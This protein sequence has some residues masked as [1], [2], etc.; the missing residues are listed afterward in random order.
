MLSSAVQFYRLGARTLHGDEFGSIDE[1]LNL[2]RNLNSLPYFSTL[3]AWLALG[4]GEFWLRTLSAL[5]MV[6]AVAVTFVWVKSLCGRSTALV[7]SLLL[8]TSP[9]LA[10]YGQQ[11][12][13]YGLA[14]LAASL[15][16]WAFTSYLILPRRTTLAKWAAAGLFALSALL[17]NALL[18]AGEFITLFALSRLSRRSKAIIGAA[19]LIVV[20]FVLLVPGVRQLGFDTL[21]KYTNAQ[22]HY[23]ASRGLALSQIAKLPLTFFFFTFGESVYPLTYWLVIPGLVFV[24]VAFVLGIWKLRS[25]VSVLAFVSIAGMT[26]LLALYLVF[27]PLSPPSLQGA[28]PRYLIFLLPLFYLVLAAGTR[29]KRSSLLIVPL[30]LVNFG[31]LASYWYGDWAYTDDL[32]DWR[33]VSQW[34]SNYVTPQTLVLVD[35][36]SQDLANRYFPSSWHIQNEWNYQSAEDLTAFSQFSRLI[37]LSSNYNTDPRA[38]VSALIDRVEYGYDQVA[39]WSKYPLFIEVFDRKQDPSPAFSVDSTGRVNIP[40]EIYGIEFQDLGLP[41]SLKLGDRIVPS[42][43]A[44]GLPGL[45]KQTARSLLLERPTTARELV[46]FS[47][48]IDAALQPGVVVANLSIVG[49]DGSTQTFPLRVGI[50]TSAWNAHCQPDACL[51]A[52]TW[53]KRLALVGSEGYPGSWQQFDA[54]VFAAELSLSSPT[55]VESIELQRLSNQGTLYVWGIALQ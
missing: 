44:F 6:A 12:R 17:L 34:T 26:A 32:T 40:S 22:S 42:L 27:D 18:I 1:A 8:A 28:A 3:R 9:F 55:L 13:F 25:N 10:V 14:L 19:F 54:S 36:R 35:G 31:G 5:A 38:Q 20:L 37:V 30:L 16:V 53:T 46:V 33:A 11:I 39:A 23:V 45:N 29:G 2:G 50:E 4:S 41:I 51:P 49:Q 48:V 21:A 52:F 47:N 43:G 24:G 15:C 7:A